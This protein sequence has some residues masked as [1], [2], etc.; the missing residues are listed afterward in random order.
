VDCRCFFWSGIADIDEQNSLML[1][2]SSSAVEEAA[3]MLLAIPVEGWAVSPL[4]E[5]F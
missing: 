1:E 3:D 5:F 4:G 2:E